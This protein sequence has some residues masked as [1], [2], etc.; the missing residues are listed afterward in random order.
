MPQKRLFLRSLAAG[1]LVPG[2]SVL[3]DPFGPARAAASAL[4]IVL[5]AVPG[6]FIGGNWIY[7]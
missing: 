4:C 2:G 5:G 7:P 6:G 3:G 1:T